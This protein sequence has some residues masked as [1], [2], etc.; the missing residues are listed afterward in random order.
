VLILHDTTEGL[1]LG[2]AASKFWTR[3]EFK[4][5][6]ALKHSVN[7]T[8]MPIEQKESY[9]RLGNLRQTTQLAQPDQCVHIGDRES[10]IYELFCE[11]RQYN[12]HFLVLHPPIGKQKRYPDLELTVLHAKEIGK[13]KSRAAIHWKL[14]T[15]LPVNDQ[16]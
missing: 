9:H 14:L 4:G 3:Q 16:K 1:P 13:P 6:N 11:A 15:D 2:I 10:D 8:R 5:T 12:I 7:P